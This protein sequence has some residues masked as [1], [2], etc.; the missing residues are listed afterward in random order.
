MY[1]VIGYICRSPM[2]KD[3]GSFPIKH[4]N[5][6]EKISAVKVFSP[7]PYPLMCA[8]HHIVG[9]YFQHVSNYKMQTLELIGESY[10]DQPSLDNDVGCNL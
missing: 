1:F 10:I 7:I 2:Q 8:V 6:F 3:C 4:L 5:I 9:F